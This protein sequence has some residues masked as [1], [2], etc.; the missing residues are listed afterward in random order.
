MKITITIVLLMSTIRLTA[1]DF[2]FIDLVYDSNIPIERYSFDRYENAEWLSRTLNIDG[3]VN[4][5][6][7]P[8]TRYLINPD[9]ENL[10]I[11]DSAGRLI[12][13]KSAKKIDVSDWSSAYYLVVN[14]EN[15]KLI[16]K[17]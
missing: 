2:V 10:I 4:V 13:K 7:N 8:V 3:E 9:N 11:Y 12:L 1:Q 6:P 14:G 17:K 16:I 5:Y 15:R